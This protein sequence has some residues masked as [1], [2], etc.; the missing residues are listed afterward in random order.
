MIKRGIRVG[1]LPGKGYFYKKDGSTGKSEV[2][3]DHAEDEEP[4]D[5][6]GQ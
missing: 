3:V 2:Y 1:K 6:A 4:K 5:R